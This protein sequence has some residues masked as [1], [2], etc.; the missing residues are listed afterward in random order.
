MARMSRIGVSPST[1]GVRPPMQKMF[2]GRNMATRPIPIIVD[3][4]EARAIAAAAADQKPKG[5]VVNMPSKPRPTSSETIFGTPV[6][7]SATV[8]GGV[9]NPSAGTDTTL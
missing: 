5:D 9:Y 2:D 8:A 6:S 4:S 7:R 3:A 1:T